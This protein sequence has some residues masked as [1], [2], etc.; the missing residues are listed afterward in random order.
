[1]QIADDFLWNVRYNGVALEE[2]IPDWLETKEF[3][4]RQKI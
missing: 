2:L 1:M 3:E 4:K